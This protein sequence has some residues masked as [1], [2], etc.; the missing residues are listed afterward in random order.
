[1][2]WLI[3][4][5]PES[6]LS[7]YLWWLTVLAPILGLAFVIAGL[8]I[9]D[10]IS[11]MQAVTKTSLEPTP[12]MQEALLSWAKERAK[13]DYE[14]LLMKAKDEANIPIQELQ[15]L[16]ADSEAR[17]KAADG[18]PGLIFFTIIEIRP[19]GNGRRQYIFDFG[20]FQKERLS[21]YISPDNIFT[22]CLYD[23]NG[24][25]HPV[26]LPIG[27]GYVPTGRKFSLGCEVGIKQDSTFLRVWVDGVEKSAVTLPFKTDIGLLNPADGVIGCDLEHSNG[28]SFDVYIHMILKEILNSTKRQDL[29]N[30]TTKFISNIS[31]SRTLRFEGNQFIG[32]GS[33]GSSALALPADESRRPRYVSP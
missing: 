21:V 32:T 9:K 18:L 4:R 27:D 16:K 1:M 24:E 10:R 3:N 15:R 8:R 28:A 6:Q 26:L 11:E 14:I 31:P 17:S 29:I 7:N 25:P 23:I 5:I 33:P 22:M 2:D 12:D 30:H 13:A 20:K 19:M